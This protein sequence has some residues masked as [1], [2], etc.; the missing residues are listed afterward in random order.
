MKTKYHIQDLKLISFH[1]FRNL[2][3]CFNRQGINHIK[4]KGGKKNE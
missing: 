1:L 3:P 2:G 4:S